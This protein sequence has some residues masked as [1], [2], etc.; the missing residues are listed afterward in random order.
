MSKGALITGGA[1]G[2]GRCLVRRFLER[3]YKVYFLDI[4]EEELEHTTKTH[5]KKYYEAGKLQSAVCNLRNIQEIQGKVKQ[6]ADFL[7][8][9][10]HVLVNN[11]GIASPK[12]K[13]GK[14]MADTDTI[15]E[16]QAYGNPPFHAECHIP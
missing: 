4:D 7:G 6:A 2:I 13:D 15:P 11:G 10:I 16:W 5:L 9:R 14:T 1:R 12:W 3:D 8:G